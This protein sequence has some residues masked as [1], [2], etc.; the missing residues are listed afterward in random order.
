MTHGRNLTRPEASIA[1]ATIMAP[2]SVMVRVGI[3]IGD[4]DLDTIAPVTVGQDIIPAADGA[5]E[6]MAHMAHTMAAMGL[7]ILGLTGGRRHAR[8]QPV[9]IIGRRFRPFR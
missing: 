8:H 5:A 1:T 3:R 6:D 7:G 4:M 9:A 2:D